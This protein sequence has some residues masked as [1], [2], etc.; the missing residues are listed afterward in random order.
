MA[1]ETEAKSENAWVSL[2]SDLAAS[3]HQRVSFPAA[4]DRRDGLLPWKA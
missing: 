4:P 3:E 1:W 2:L